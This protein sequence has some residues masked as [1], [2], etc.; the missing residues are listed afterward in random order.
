MLL[1]SCN[2]NGQCNNLPPTF[3]SYSQAIRLIQNTRFTYTD[4]LPSEKSSWISTANYYSCNGVDGY[5]IY[6]TTKG[7]RY[8]HERIP[9]N[10]WKEF[11]NASSSGS[12][13]V[14]N[15]KNRYRLIP[16]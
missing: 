3:S 1:Y 2:T 16:D 12:F 11:K 4:K 15:I 9:L 7:R 10:V 5:M 6:S 13:Y 8:M 14:S